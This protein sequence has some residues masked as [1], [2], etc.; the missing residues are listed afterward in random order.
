MSSERSDPTLA[1]Y[2]AMAI[3]PALIMGLVGSLVFFLLEVF[4]SGQYEGRLQWILF[5]FVF[6]AVLIAR[7]SM[8][9]DIAGRANLYGLTLGFLVWLGMQFYVEYP[10][11]SPAAHLS[12]LIN[13]VLVG[14]VWWCAHRLTWDCTH[15]PEDN[16][17]GGEGLLQEAAGTGHEDRGPT[18]EGEEGAK[19]PGWLERY[20]RYR[21]EKKKRRA[22]GVWVVYFSLAALPLFGLGQSLIPPGDPRR[23][24]AF[25]LI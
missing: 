15:L 21:E 4:Y 20:R 5:F 9:G 14:L 19:R 12:F 16:D 17:P 7:V 13:L 3:S 18:A 8:M 23:R 22:L 10:A 24:T 2:V 1:D 25:W 6:G 11:D